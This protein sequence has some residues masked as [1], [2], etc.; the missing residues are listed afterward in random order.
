MNYKIS[1][2]MSIYIK[3]NPLHFDRAMK[4]IYDE[5]FLKPDEIVLVLDGNLT[6]EL[7]KMIEF[8]Q[9]KLLNIL[10]I[11]QLEKNEGTGVAKNIGLKNC[12]YEFIAIMDTDDISLPDR[13]EKQIKNFQENNE[14]D[15]CSAFIGE[16]DSN[17]NDIISYRKLPEKYEEIIKFAKSRSP[18]NHP[19]TM[20]KKSIVEKAG[21]YQHMFWLEDYYLAIRMIMNGAKF[22]NI[23]EC[24]LKARIGN[25]LLLRRSGIKY[26]KAELI[27]LNELKKIKYLTNLEYYKNILIRIPVR[28]L[29]KTLLKYVY[30][31]LRSK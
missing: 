23:Q 26:V 4:S 19:V 31:L 25:G 8:W 13:L 12:S 27:F 7:Y 14:I 1:V 17:E 10:K 28:L 11:I 21:G 20:F 29:P 6:N 15:V 5:Q 18:F 3:E 24:L 16:F 22:Y 30:K 2:L 9:N